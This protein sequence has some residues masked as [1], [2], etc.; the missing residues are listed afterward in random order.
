MS[1]AR[2]IEQQPPELYEQDYFAWMSM[3]NDIDGFVYADG[4]VA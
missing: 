2:Q 4:P 1:T 3:V